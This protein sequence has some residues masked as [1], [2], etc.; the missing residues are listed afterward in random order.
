LI[1]QPFRR[2]CTTTFDSLYGVI[3]AQASAAHDVGFGNPDTCQRQFDTAALAS[4]QLAFF[5]PD[6]ILA[7]ADPDPATR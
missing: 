3:V 7:D 5:G 6:A 4:W 1:L 2:P